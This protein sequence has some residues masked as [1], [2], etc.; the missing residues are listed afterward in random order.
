MSIG[1]SNKRCKIDAV[2]FMF[3]VS[4]FLHHCTIAVSIKM[5]IFQ[6]ATG[7]RIWIGGELYGQPPI[8]PKSFE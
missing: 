8:I 5:H 1:E 3:V 4:K 7:Q 6:P 2:P